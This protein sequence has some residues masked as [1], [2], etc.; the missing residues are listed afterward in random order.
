MN[1]SWHGLC[2]TWPLFPWYQ[3]RMTEK[4]S[5][6]ARVAT[7][8]IK[9]RTFDGFKR[10]V[11]LFQANTPGPVIAEEF[12]VSRQRVN[13]WKKKLGNERTTYTL[14]PDVAELL[15]GQPSHSLI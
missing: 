6:S 1:K 5:S 2:L 12:G 13:Q 7:N 15:K 10:L 14:E 9:L 11:E 3:F 8:I 4:L